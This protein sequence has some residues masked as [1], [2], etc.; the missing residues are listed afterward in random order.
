MVQSRYVI[1]VKT[2][3]PLRLVQVADLHSKQFGKGNCRLLEKIRKET[4][5]IILFTGDTFDDSGKKREEMLAF[6]S[7]CGAIAPVVFIGGNHERRLKDRGDLWEQLREQEKLTLLENSITTFQICGQTVSFLGLDEDQG[8][9][10]AYYAR[11]K[12]S[13]NYG[14]YGLLFHALEQ[15]EGIRLVLSHYPENFALIGEK[16]YRQY[17]FDVMFAG[18]AHGGQFRF[19]IIGGLYAPGQGLFPKYTAGIHGKRPFLVISRG[20][21]RSSL[22]LRLFNRPELVSV[23]INPE[24]KQAR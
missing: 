24:E 19:P 4:P 10:Q 13:Y 2:S 8:S 16:S 17:D 14:E 20:L 7:D 21:G 3:A 6:L 23:V 15:K 9:Y 5:D 1:R 22:Y 18:H 11:A 12:G